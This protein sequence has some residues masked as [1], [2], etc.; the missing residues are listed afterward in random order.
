MLHIFVISS[1]CRSGQKKYKGAVKYVFCCMQLSYYLELA[2]RN[3]STL[4]LDI[5]YNRIKIMD[6]SRVNISIYRTGNAGG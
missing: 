2:T 6:D 5:N 4:I 1:S 3:Q